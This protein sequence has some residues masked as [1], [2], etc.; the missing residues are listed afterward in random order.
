MRYISTRGLC[1]PM[2][3]PD[4]LLSGLAPDGGLILPETLPR[5]SHLLSGQEDYATL[6]S[7]VFAALLPDFLEE[8]LNKAAQ[9]AYQGPFQHPEV[10]PLSRVGDDYVLELYHGPT[11][12]FKDLA[13]Q[14]LP[15]LLALARDKKD[16]HTQYLILTA[17]SGDTGSAAMRGFFGVPG[18]RV[19]VYYPSAGVSAVQEQQ[20]LAL[21]RG[22]ARAVGISG[23]FDQAQQGVKQAFSQATALEPSGI[24][25]SSANSINLGRLVPQVVYYIKA[26]RDLMMAGAL[27]KGDKAD[28]IVPTGNFGDILAGYLA[29]R[30]GLP[31]GQLV[32][33]TNE[34]SVLNDFLRTGVYDRR[35]TLKKT[36]SPSM[37]IL[38]SSNLERLLFYAAR[39]D[40]A[41]V[42]QLMLDLHERGWY[43]A[44]PGMMADIKKDFIAVTCDD[45]ATLQEIKRVWEEHHT[46]LDPHAAVAFTGMRSLPDSKNP[47]VVLATASPFKFPE[48]VLAALGKACPKEAPVG[49]LSD[50]TGIAPPMA[51]MELKDT[52]PARKIVIDPD[53]IPEDA[54]RRALLW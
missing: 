29:K 14:A 21:S 17:T 8:Q 49:A 4:A 7:R 18:F 11:C 12:A 10:T 3:G 47:R 32:I 31:I 9:S 51:L 27:K 45:R 34:N 54:S 2:D 13:L 42:R 39:E 53:T 43:Q 48:A 33:A 38:V 37:D 23:D 26:L 15:R 1:K 5:L 35:R 19:L 36:H 6:A 50:A 20:M 41:L 44:S 28:F 22:N 25:L 24:R 16:S 30:M 40:A 52:R 46:L